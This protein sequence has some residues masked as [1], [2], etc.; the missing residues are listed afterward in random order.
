MKVELTIDNVILYYNGLPD[1]GNR[2]NGTSGLSK[3]ATTIY[4][5]M[6]LYFYGTVTENHITK[7]DAKLNGS[8]IRLKD[9]HKEKMYYDANIIEF[10]RIYPHIICKLYEREKIRFSPTELGDL[11]SFLT[12]NYKKISTDKRLKPHAKEI[13][14]F[15]LYT[16]YALGANPYSSNYTFTNHDLV[17]DYSKETF[18]YIY[19]H[20]DNIMYIDTDSVYYIGDG[21]KICE[22]ID[23]L[24][25]PY[26]IDTTMVYFYKLKNYIELYNGEVKVRGLGGGRKRKY[27]TYAEDVDDNISKMNN[28]V[29]LRKINKLLNR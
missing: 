5:D 22:Y 20:Y 18:H 11:Y 16:T 10:T 4:K 23:W 19:T 26:T 28:R 25:I 27:P 6:I 9:E 21:K 1:Y 2:L 8:Y 15:L 13:H 29:R 3:I 14:H 12:Y 24:E 17:V 7:P